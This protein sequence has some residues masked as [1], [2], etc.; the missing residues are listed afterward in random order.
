MKKKLGDM[1]MVVY[2]FEMILM[3]EWEDDRLCIGG[4]FNGSKY[5]G[6]LSVRV[7]KNAG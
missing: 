4:G 2:L 7:L 5:P 6:Y 3:G 1:W